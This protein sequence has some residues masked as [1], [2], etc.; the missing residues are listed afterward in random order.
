MN[1]LLSLLA[2]VSIKTVLSQEFRCPPNSTRQDSS[3]QSFG[4]PTSVGT[5]WRGEEVSCPDN[6]VL[7]GLGCSGGFCDNI[8]VRCNQIQDQNQ[9]TFTALGVDRGFIIANSE[10]SAV[11]CPT[12]TVAVKVLCDGPFCSNVTMECAPVALGTYQQ[13]ELQEQIRFQDDGSDQCSWSPAFSSELNGGAGQCDDSRFVRGLRCFGENCD[14]KQLLCCAGTALSCSAPPA[15]SPTSLTPESCVGIS[16]VRLNLTT[17]GTTSETEEFGGTYRPKTYGQ[18]PSDQLLVGASCSE[19]DCGFKTLK[20][21][22]VKDKG[23]YPDTYG[24]FGVEA[25]SDTIFQANQTV[26]CAQ[27]KVAVALNCET[28]LPECDALRIRCASVGLT[29][30]RPDNFAITEVKFFGNE[31]ADRCRWTDGLSAENKSS[32]CPENTFVRGVRCD[33]GN[34]TKVSFKCC[35]GIALTCA[36]PNSALTVSEVE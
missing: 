19:S 10:S 20:C 16:R 9:R 27:N 30:S 7:A 36:N 12:N 24:Y 34:C 1:V 4:E 25:W 14:T 32:Q 31:A 35:P 3:L 26:E 11:F 6:S 21:Q 15:G 28:N 2:V 5:F 23:R 17:S 22:S 29:S 33:T 18:C 13:N 8:D